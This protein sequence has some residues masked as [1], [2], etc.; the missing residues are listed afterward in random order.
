MSRDRRHS[1]ID[2]RRRRSSE[3]MTEEP[4]VLLPQ[5][6]RLETGAPRLLMLPESGPT[7]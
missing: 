5:G 3:V 1:P 7:V 4:V 2:Q 6:D